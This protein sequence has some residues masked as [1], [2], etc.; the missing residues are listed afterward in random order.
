M[1][2][3]LTVSLVERAS[4][5]IVPSLW[6]A[7]SVV[8][9]SWNLAACEESSVGQRLNRTCSNTDRHNRNPVPVPS[10]YGVYRL[11]YITGCDLFRPKGFRESV[12]CSCQKGF[13]PTNIKQTKT[14]NR[15]GM[16]FIFKTKMFVTPLC[17]T[18]TM[19]A[20]VCRALQAL[21]QTYQSCMQF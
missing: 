13:N 10:S 2:L 7:E 9:W 8:Q 1:G 12:I 17:L 16:P 15:V 3:A 6:A 18:K 20:P 21:C 11:A 5:R 14:L 19:R 4:L